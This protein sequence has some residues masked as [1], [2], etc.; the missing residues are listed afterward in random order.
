MPDTTHT[1]TTPDR[2]T[3]L[4]AVA[5]F[6][7]VFSRPD[8]AA[9]LATRLRCREVDALAEMLRAC[10]QVDAADLWIEEHATDDDEGDA[11]HT[12]RGSEQ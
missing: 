7:L 11:H 5:E 10:G 8:T 4:D 12:E 1:N 3:F 2:P 6:A 9:D